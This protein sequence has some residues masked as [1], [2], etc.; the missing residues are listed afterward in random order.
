MLLCFLSESQQTQSHAQ[1][2]LSYWHVYRGNDSFSGK[3]VYTNGSSHIHT[4]H[5]EYLQ[6]NKTENTSLKEGVLRQVQGYRKN[7]S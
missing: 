2:Q 1:E 4:A 6:V 3:L 7:L 5:V